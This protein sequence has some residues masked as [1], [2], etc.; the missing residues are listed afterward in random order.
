MS[1]NSYYWLTA[2]LLLSEKS[3]LEANLP[4][5][6]YAENESVEYRHRRH[7][8]DAGAYYTDE[9]LAEVLADIAIERRVEPIAE[10]V[11][12][13]ARND[14]EEEAR[15][16]ADGLLD[17]KICDPTVGGGVFLSKLAPRL[18]DVLNRVRE[19][20][21][22]E[23]LELDHEALDGE[24]D[25]A[26]HVYSRMLY[27][28]DLDERA[29]AD[30]CSHIA[31]DSSL[32]ESEVRNLIAPNLKQGN[33]LLDPV[34]PEAWPNRNTLHFPAKLGQLVGYRKRLREGQR[35]AE[36][37][38]ECLDLKEQIVSRTAGRVLDR[39]PDWYLED[40]QPFCWPLEFPEA[41]Y[42]ENGRLLDSPGFD[43]IIGNP[44]WDVVKCNDREFFDTVEP[45]FSQRSRAKRDELKADLLE[46][47]EVRA[48]YDR[49]V[50]RIEHF[51]DFV[52][53]D[54]YYRH[55]TSGRYGHSYNKYKLATELAYN[56]ASEGGDVLLITPSGILGEAGSTALRELL[57]DGGT[58]D[59]FWSFKARS[60]VF[61][62][63]DQN[64]AIQIYTKGGRTE[65]L[66]YVDGIESAD[67]FGR[68]YHSDEVPQISGELVREA[69][70]E[71][72]S[73]IPVRDETGLNVLD[74][75]T[76]HPLAGDDSGE[77]WSVTPS[78]EIDETNDRHHIVEEETAYPFVKGRCVFP[79]DLQPEVI[80]KWV[81]ADFLETECE[82]ANESRVVWRDV[83]RPSLR[84][85][86]FV[87]VVPPEHGI[88]N[89][90]NYVVPDQSEDEK[91]YLAAVMQSWAFEYRARQIS[92]NSHLNMYV[93][94]QVPVPRLDAD[95][96]LFESIVSRTREILNRDV[97]DGR[98]ESVM[99]EI[100]ALVAHA[101][102]LDDD[103]LEFVLDSY[104][105]L[106][107]ETKQSILNAYA[108]YR[109]TMTQVMGDPPPPKR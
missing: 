11:E 41:F 22:A 52:K 36:T 50:E 71:T 101:Y 105:K 60:D 30:A 62:G 13:A 93:I 83:A 99:N 49:Y 37:L 14:A 97:E 58:V 102:G 79:Y 9:H 100:D 75:L 56:V 69:A 2:P 26:E 86:M 32:S 12:N 85:R 103:E 109:G 24:R 31:E 53:S 8:K 48:D 47:D 96:E 65:N 3:E 70:P 90:L 88:G 55:Q 1:D 6:F 59:S 63:V 20:V 25:V 73:L 95:T 35:D 94:R 81:E 87:T 29:L 91:L 5:E 82:H 40:D 74:T 84:R 28:V 45:D 4:D 108:N 43:V 27:G 34:P 17:L 46:D 92:T 104:E 89:S 51:L 18:E 68:L 19:V 39:F 72:F 38:R 77:Y 67:E 57:F 80:D 76:S 106:E 7:Q 44:P 21:S 78:R 54:T 33:A 98:R 61:E 107:T 15:D 10:K 23:G 66:R 64:P 42:D 16:L